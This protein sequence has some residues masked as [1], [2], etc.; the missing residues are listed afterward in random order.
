MYA[1]T[2]IADRLAAAEREFSV[3]P[4]PHTVDEVI[5]FEEHLRRQGMY[6]YDDQG[7]VSG[8][9]NLTEFERDWMLNEQLLVQCDARYALT[10]YAFIKDEQ[11]IIRRFEFRIPQEILF[12]VIQDLE[13]LGGSIELMCLKARQ[14]GVSTLIILLV[15]LR[16]IF[17]YGV[18]AVIGSADQTKTSLMAN[19]LFLFYDNLPFWMRPR[20]TRRVESDRG[21]LV[22]GQNAAGVSFQHGAQTSGIARGTTPTVYLLSEC[23]SFTN[24][25]EQIEAALFKAVHASPAVFGVLEST[26]EGD[27][28][29]WPDT[30]RDSK[31]KWPKR[32][33]RLCPKFLPWF[34]GVNM[35]PTPTWIRMRPVPDSWM[36]NHDT[37]LHVAK[38]E[39]FVQSDELLRRH[40][41]EYQ[42]RTGILAPD[43]RWRMPRAQQWFWEVEHEQ[44]K[45]KSIE[46][47][48]LQE[49]AGDDEEALQRSAESAFGHHTIEMIEERRTRTYVAY[50]LSG[51]SI[52]DAHE[53]P[54][55]D[56][57]YAATRVPV[58]FASARETYRWDFIPLRFASPLDESD[59]ADTTGKLLVWHQPRPNVSYSIGV[60]TSEGKGQ[61]STAVSVWALGARGTPDIQCAE[62]AS[63]YVNHVEAFA[64]VLAIAAY[65]GQHMSQ[66][67]CRWKQPYVSIEQVASVGDTCQLQMAKMGYTNF[68]RMARYDS[69]P[70]KIMRSKRGTAGKR[71]W[72][73]FGWSRPLLTGNF[74][75]AAQNGWAEI[76][77]PWLLDEMKHYE[78]HV[79]STGKEK[80]EHE[81]GAH[82]D[83]IMAAAMAIFC[84]HDMDTLAERSNKRIEEKATFPP[85]DL[86]EYRGS[87]FSAAEL[88]Q[89]RPLTLEDVMYQD[90]KLERFSR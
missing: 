10:R 55:E 31:L 47:I 49:M 23:A 66:G 50:G 48:F 35:Y 20:T 3:V 4:E 64:F 74:V 30:W 40:L 68:H 29:W 24:P 87:T 17:A 77:S 69:T 2:V 16:I 72:F 36:P 22:F 56:I 44:A 58:R 42:R 81:D 12:G 70:Q 15:A 18:N 85:I 19:M 83:R 73:S 33:A 60:D 5:A 41:T 14:L 32:R 9:Q 89:T 63:P 54:P 82:D 28:G 8:T 6:V 67:G 34:C 53:P 59:P 21:M 52:E 27:K 45:A 65:Y 71:G 25:V 11:N 90:A 76:N 78:V 7:I 46:S 1:P 80:L 62:F 84:P 75:H 39:L 88:K 13:L 61:D 43:G 57:D 86:G 38:S 79:T 26:G 37:R 51:Q